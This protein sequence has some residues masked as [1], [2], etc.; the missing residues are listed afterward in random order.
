MNKQE[1]EN[2]LIDFAANIIIVAS[3][4]K[5]NYAGN[6]LGG[7]IIRSGTSPALNYGEAQSAESTKDFIHKMGIC[8]KELRETFVCLRI[9]EKSSLTSDLNNLMMAKTEVNE[10]ISIFVTSIKTAKTNLK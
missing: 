5:G 9:V 7:Q 2:R 3:M 1:L 10:L 8:L 4:F 6:H